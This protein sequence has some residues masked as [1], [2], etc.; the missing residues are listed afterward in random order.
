MRAHFVAEIALVAT[1]LASSAFAQAAAE[2]VL[3]NGSSA[4][5]TVKAGSAIGGALDRANRNMGSRMQTITHAKQSGTSR[6]SYV[7]SGTASPRV[8]R[9]T[10]QAAVNPSVASK[11]NGSLIVSVQGGRLT[12]SKPAHNATP[13]PESGQNPTPTDSKPHN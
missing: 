5:S 6:S 11:S 13:S 9:P 8:T 3:L 2:S 4:A 12:S 1:A 10:S 7:R